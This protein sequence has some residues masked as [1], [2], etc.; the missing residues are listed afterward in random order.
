MRGSIISD[1]SCLI[2][3]N[4][5][6]ELRLLAD[7][8]ETVIITQAIANEYS[9][10]VPDWIQIRN[11][12]NTDL[13]KAIELN[14][15]KGESSAIAFSFEIS[16]PLLILDDL[17]ARKY[18]SKLGISYTGTL[19]VI[20]LGKEKEKIHSVKSILKKSEILISEFLNHLK[21]RC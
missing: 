9:D 7:V 5:I 2:L 21:I 17:K 20:L 11:P 15:D 6:G 3:L 16:Y 10:H 8:F 18:A 14:L 19:G 13:Q 12:E 1:S 4:K